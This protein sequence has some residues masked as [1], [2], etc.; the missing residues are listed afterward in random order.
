[1]TDIVEERDGRL[2][3]YEIKYAVKK[4][5]KPPKSWLTAYPEADFQIITPNNYQDF[6]LLATIY[7]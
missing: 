4:K 3:G 6:V 1:M 7:D 2:H 5:V